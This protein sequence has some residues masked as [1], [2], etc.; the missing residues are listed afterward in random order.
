LVTV[1][2]LELAAFLLF[3]VMKRGSD[4]RF[5]EIRE[6]CLTFFAFWVWQASGSVVLVLLG[7]QTCDRQVCFG[8]GLHR[9]N[10]STQ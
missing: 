5:D 9:L 7:L 1:S 8:A 4:A 3:R 2:R 6:G 10:H